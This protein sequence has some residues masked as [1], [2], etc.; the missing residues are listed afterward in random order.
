M[1]SLAQLPSPF[2][3][4]SAYFYA[5]TETDA[6]PVS[7]LLNDPAIAE[8]GVKSIIDKWGP[9][10]EI[11]GASLWSYGYFLRLLRPVLAYG[12]LADVWFDVSPDRTSA[13]LT[14][15]GTL[16]HFHVDQRLP[17]KVAL[18]EMMTHL[19]MAIVYCSQSTRTKERLHRSNAEYVVFRAVSQLAAMSMTGEQ[20]DRIAAVQEFI[21]Q[22][23]RFGLTI[24]QA[25]DLTRRRVCCL[26]D[27]LLGLSRCSSACPL[28]T[29]R[30]CQ[31]L[32]GPQQRR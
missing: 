31:Q 7:N 12:V 29:S 1:Q 23:P 17:R 27:R 15:G 3:D 18:S 25:S 24:D 16:Q 2:S 20:R 30:S 13:G 11:A 8:R 21:S 32:F 14:P 5:T 22:S 10:D 19:D 4:C 26:R 6:L 9:G 28:S